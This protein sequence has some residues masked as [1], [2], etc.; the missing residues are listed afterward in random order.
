MRIKNDNSGVI[1][2]IINSA[3]TSAV[4]ILIQKTDIDSSVL[5]MN[6]EYII[7]ADEVYGDAYNGKYIL[8]RKREMYVREN[9]NFTMNT[10]LLFEKL[11][12]NLVDQNQIEAKKIH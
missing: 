10:M 6:K 8:I 11:P 4:Q 7:H 2:N 3:N 1:D 12:D 5:T 9:N